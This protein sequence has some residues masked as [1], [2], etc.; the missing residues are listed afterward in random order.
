MRRTVLLLA[1]MLLSL[2]VLGSGSPK[3][4]DGRIKVIEGTWRLIQTEYEGKKESPPSYEDV[5]TCYSGILADSKSSS[6]CKYRI[7][8]GP[9]GKPPHLDLLPLSGTGE[10]EK[11]IYQVDGDTLRT[12]SFLIVFGGEETH[13]PREFNG[14]NVLVNTYKR[15]K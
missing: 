13:R 8:P 5:I 4:Y 2:V 7:D 3:E 11:C 1:G 9:T 6:R 10:A 15:V 12:A 14:D